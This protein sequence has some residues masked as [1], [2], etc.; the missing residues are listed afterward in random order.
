MRCSEDSSDESSGRSD[1]RGRDLQKRP[2]ST[3]IKQ[4]GVSCA[5]SNAKNPLSTH[6]S[7]HAIWEMRRSAKDSS[8]GKA[9]W[10]LSDITFHSPSANVSFL[11][12][13][14][15]ARS[16][17]EILS[18]RHAVKLL[19]NVVGKARRLDDITIKPLTLDTW[20]L[21]SLV[22]YISDVA[23][24]RTGQPVSA[25]PSLQANRTDTA[26]PRYDGKPSDDFGIA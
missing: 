20:F 23:E 26:S 1:N 13:L 14:F 7:S 4:S 16:D 2:K 24:R 22:D 18:P 5:Q 11:T 19:E 3:A 9:Q 25:L 17:L 15:R 6:A 21:M 12:A 8:P 10:H